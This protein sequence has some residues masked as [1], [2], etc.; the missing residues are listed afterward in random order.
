MILTGTGLGGSGGAQCGK[1]TKVVL[2][3]GSHI[4][5]CER[6]GECA[7]VAAEWLGQQ[8]R[9]F[10]ADE[11]LVRS[12]QSEKSERDL[13]VLSKRWT[14]EVRKPMYALRPVKGKL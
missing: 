7:T 2:E 9:Q 6:V 12:Y 11:E 13:L 4:V 10:K 14:S 8:V 5:P 3:N 1:V